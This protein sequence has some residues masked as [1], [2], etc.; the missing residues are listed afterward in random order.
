MPVK[1][2]AHAVAT[3]VATRVAKRGFWFPAHPTPAIGG[4]WR[5]LRVPKVL[6]YCH[7]WSLVSSSR[8]KSAD[9]CRRPHACSLLCRLGSPGS[10]F[11]V[12]SHKF[13]SLPIYLYIYTYVYLSRRVCV[14][15]FLPTYT[16]TY[17]HTT[18]PLLCNLLALITASG[19][20]G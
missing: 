6:R 18:W 11:A 15:V 16:H 8:S 4:F 7:F 1:Q 17:I 2:L 14:C 13:L 10:F 19:C 5:I 3:P 9:S 20:S 12:V